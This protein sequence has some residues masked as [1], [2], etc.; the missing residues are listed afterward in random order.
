MFQPREKW[1]GAERVA[2]GCLTIVR[3][4]GERTIYRQGGKG[5]I[6]KEGGRALAF[7]WS[8]LSSTPKTEEVFYRILRRGCKTVGPGGPGLVW[9]HGY[10][11]ALV[12]HW[13]GGEPLRV[14]SCSK[15][16]NHKAILSLIYSIYLN[17]NLTRTLMHIIE[18]SMKVCLHSN[19]SLDILYPT[20]CSSIYCQ[21]CLCKNNLYSYQYT[22]L[23]DDCTI[24]LEKSDKL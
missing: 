7:Q 15:T 10:F 4:G 17:S 13:F 11:Q 2:L 6:R 8:P 24:Y 21:L 1:L 12:S 9:L 22:N 19:Y 18:V 3:K 14:N 16:K 23:I 5:L 20:L